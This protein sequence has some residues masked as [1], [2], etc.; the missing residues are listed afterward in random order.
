MKKSLTKILV[1]VLALMLSYALLTPVGALRAG[2][3]LS[4]HPLSALTLQARKAT[5]DDVGLKELDNPAGTTVYR[6]ER[7]VPIDGRTTAKLE[8]WIVERFG[9]VCV[10][11]YY[12]YC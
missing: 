5:A 7:S 8:N 1:A 9:P 2:V 6:V 12:G 4:G 11:R 10:A 3:F